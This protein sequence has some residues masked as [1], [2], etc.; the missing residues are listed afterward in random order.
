MK[1]IICFLVV[2]ST[3]ASFSQ[4]ENL[5]ESYGTEKVKIKKAITTEEM[6]TDF[7]KKGEPKEYT[8]KGKLVKV[9]PKAGCWVSIDKGDGETFTVKFKDHFTI[10]IDTETGSD[11]Y[12]HGI[13]SIRTVTVEQLQA[14]AK[15]RGE[16]DEEIEK[17]TESKSYFFFKGDGIQLTV[18]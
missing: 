11:V 1:N 13:A 3:F 2:M 7:Y 17:I 4:K 16:S 15:D 9:C 14:A 6:L 12:V 18:K 5:G 10:P 8:F